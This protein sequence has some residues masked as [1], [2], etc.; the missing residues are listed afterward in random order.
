MSSYMKCHDIVRQYCPGAFCEDR[1]L[2]AYPVSTKL[3]HLFIKGF[4]CE[5]L[6]RLLMIMHLC[7]SIF[8]RFHLFN[9]SKKQKRSL[10]H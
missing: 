2:R 10:T 6:P 8:Y 1:S 9:A 4:S 5:S 3:T 7:N